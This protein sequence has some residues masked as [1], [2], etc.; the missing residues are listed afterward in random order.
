MNLKIMQLILNIAILGFNFKYC[1][2]KQKMQ[3]VSTIEVMV[4]SKIDLVASNN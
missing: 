3:W 1:R 2:Y 4:F